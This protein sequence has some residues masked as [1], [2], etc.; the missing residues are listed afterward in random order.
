MTGPGPRGSGWSLRRRLLAAVLGLLA[1]V[2]AVIA[3]LGVVSVKR[4]LTEQLDTQ[5]SAAVSR[6][7]RA[8]DRMQD[9]IGPNGELRPDR[10]PGVLGPVP[11]FLE[12]PGQPEGTLGAMLRDGRVQRAAVLDETGT[13]R[14]IGVAEATV[15][16]DVPSDGRPRTVDLGPELGEYRVAAV[17]VTDDRTIVTGLS[18][19]S[20]Q[21]T[22]ARL[23]VMMALIAVLGLLLAAVAGRAIVRQTLRPLDRVAATASRV[24]ELPLDTGE[25]VLRDRVPEEDTDPGTEVGQVGAALNR[26]LG[27]VAAAL[28]AR[29]ESERRVRQFVADASHE[30]RTPLAAIRGYAELTRRGSEPIPEDVSFA[31]ARVES[32]AERM[33]GLVEDLLLLARLDSGDAGAGRRWEDVELSGL[34]VDAVSDARVA[35]PDHRWELVLPAEPVV[36]RG[37]RDRLHQ[38]LANLLSNARVHTPAGTTVT[39]GLTVLGKGAGSGSVPS[40]GA[41]P[42]AGVVQGVASGAGSGTASGPTWVRLTVT[43]DGPGIP[44]E[45]LSHVFER[46]R[47][48]DGS[49]SRASGSSGLGLAIVSAVVAAH[50]GSVAA[51][52]V[53]GRTELTVDLPA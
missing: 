51:S 43:D 34:L 23:A 38:V 1:F 40:S 37:D 13:G 14:P 12:I 39:T 52:S 6:A 30:L 32:E 17:S 45:L 2:A 7:D 33:S 49:R 8:A 29:E 36:V 35:G 22:V 31:L 27:H 4:V 53:P 20:V 5:L 10:E 48:G 44:A 16:E 41:V 21:E 50:G 24:A 28:T 9:G 18:L 46:F 26:L 11:V 42:G 15:L 47:R 19:R 3:V 25:V